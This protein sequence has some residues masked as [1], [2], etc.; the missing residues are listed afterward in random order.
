M[1]L[2]EALNLE[3]SQAKTLITHARTGTAR[4]LSYEIHAI[5]NDAKQTNG[6]RSVN[7]RIGF[8]V[9]KG[10]IREKRQDYTEEGKPTHRP[11]LLKDS[12]Y[13]IISTYQAEY[14]GIVE[15]YRMAHNLSTLSQLKWDMERSLTKTLASKEQIPVTQVYRR[16]RA[17]ITVAS[18]PYKGLQVTVEREGKKPLVATWGAI[19]LK[20]K[21]KGPVSDQPQQQPWNDRSELEKRLLAQICEH[22]GA[23]RLTETIQVHHIRALKDLNRYEGREKPVWVK[24]M[25]ARRRKT[26]VLCRT[27]HHNLHAGRP[28]K[29]KRSHSRTGPP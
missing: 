4:F 12:V 14:R 11:E 16:Y 17:T 10:I 18:K 19:P 8:R 7:G 23:T 15:Y 20:W 29:P 22:C 24:I 28:L 5:H 26:L 9:P 2:R 3:L 25:V 13:T 21:V 27:C 1:F 6:R